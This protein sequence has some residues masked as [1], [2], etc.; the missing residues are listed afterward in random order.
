[1]ERVPLLKMCRS[2]LSPASKLSL[3]KAF[4]KNPRDRSQS[5]TKTAAA[6]QAGIPPTLAAP[7]G[8]RLQGDANNDDPTMADRSWQAP[9][10][11]AA[12]VP[13]GRSDRALPPTSPAGPA[14]PLGAVPRQNVGMPFMA[15]ANVG[16]QFN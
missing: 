13:V 1:M 11:L 12:A 16:A 10:P 7:A 4:S 5:A 15:P 9:P 8:L 2:T 6:L 3:K 14:L